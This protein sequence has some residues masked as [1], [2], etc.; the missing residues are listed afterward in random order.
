MWIHEI[1]PPIQSG[2]VVQPKSSFIS[3]SLTHCS[4]TVTLWVFFLRMTIS[5]VAMN[6]SFRPSIWPG[7]MLIV[8]ILMAEK[9]IWNHGH[10]YSGLAWSKLAVISILAVSAFGRFLYSSMTQL[11]TFK[12]NL[13]VL[14]VHILRQRAFAASSNNS[15]NVFAGGNCS[16]C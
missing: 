6:F 15:C 7:L 3:F 11:G 10:G 14:G 16:P 1:R 13:F 5:K 12:L 9:I 8:D 4:S 2:N